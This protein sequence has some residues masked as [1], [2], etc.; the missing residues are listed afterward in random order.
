MVIIDRTVDPNRTV[1]EIEADCGI[2]LTLPK[3]L[4]FAEYCKEKLENHPHV[5]DTFTLDQ[6]EV[7]VL[8]TSVFE[9][10]KVKIKTK[11]F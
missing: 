10:L 5:G 6:Y 11:L 8:E 7:T 4:I 3:D 2:H 1:A 9:I